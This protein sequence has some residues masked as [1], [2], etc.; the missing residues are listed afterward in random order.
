MSDATMLRTAQARDRFLANGTYDDA[1]GVRPEIVKSWRRSLMY[2]LTPARALPRATPEQNPDSQLLR[3][4][5]PIL[6][7]RRSALSGLSAALTLTDQDGTLIGRWVEDRGFARR[8]DARQVL[9]G[10]CIAE[11]AIGTSSSGISLETGHAVVVVGHEHFSDGAVTMTTAGTPIRHPI[12]RR[13]IGTLNLTCAAVDTHSL[14]LPWITEL[15]ADIERDLLDSSARSQR[16]LL[17]AFLT[18]VQDARHPVVC[19]DENTVISNAAA[20]RL[21]D[22]ADS[23]LL[24]ELAGRTLAGADLRGGQVALSTGYTVDVTCDAVLDGD[25]SVGAL[26]RLSRVRAK[27]SPNSPDIPAA[28]PLPLLDRLPGRSAAWTRFRN[29][30]G[31]AWSRQS[32][33]LILGESGTGKS[34]VADTLTESGG[35]ACVLDADTVPGP[36]LLRALRGELAD[37]SATTIILR[38]IDLLSA[39]DAAA[40]SRLLAATVPPG[41]R[42]VATAQAAGD[43]DP[44][45][46]RLMDW[47]GTIAVA[48]PLRDRLDDLPELLAAMTSKVRGGSIGPRWSAEVVQ[49][50]SRLAWPANLHTLHGVV[51]TV[52]RDV[53][54]S[55]VLPGDLPAGLAGRGSRRFLT[56]LERA[57]AH[58]IIAAL[59]AAEG[60]KREAAEALG[61]ARST[62]YRKMR[63]LGLSLSSSTF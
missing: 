45:M 39:A 57:E 2:G 56:G 52:S 32:P 7:S 63:A 12:T 38:R 16:I 22:S 24:W 50:L 53:V 6:E 18:S 9:P 13:V 29:R 54:G 1:L 11:G 61:I 19:L 42:V 34:V 43:D 8:L 21:L 33:L 47:P 40:T 15:V 10:M 48:P 62:L 3:A 14:L 58:T 27:F 37:A 4:A 31:Q 20:A 36:E 49:V 55:V 25:R 26:L 23:A 30:A 17:D 28:S 59:R 60:N 5:G 46:S 41:V 51:A 44:A 35:P